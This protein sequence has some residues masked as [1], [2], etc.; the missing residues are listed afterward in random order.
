[1]DFTYPNSLF[2]DCSKCGLC[3]GDTKHKTRHILLL[4]SEAS[5]ISAETKLPRQDFANQIKDKA[6]YCFEMKKP[7][8][9]KCFF[10]KDDQCS[11]YTLRPLI[12]R[13]YPFE[14]KFDPDK[15]LHIFDFTNECPAISKGK[16]ITV[17][18]FEELFA[19]AK[20][21]LR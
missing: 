17:K 6:P 21:R 8:K 10:L 16:I 11:I 2:F 9:G 13:F 5:D 4:K 1:M 3:C 20:E 7:K 12:C 19:L 14:L 15:D 18:D